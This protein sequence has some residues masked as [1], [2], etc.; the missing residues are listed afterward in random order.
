MQLLSTL[1]T[2]R[3][4]WNAQQCFKSISNVFMTEIAQEALLSLF[5]SDDKNC[6]VEID[7]ILRIFKIKLPSQFKFWLICV[8]FTKISILIMFLSIKKAKFIKIYKN[9]LFFC[10]FAQQN[11]KKV[12]KTLENHVFWYFCSKNLKILKK[13][14]KILWVSPIIHEV[15]SSKKNK[16]S[17]VTKK[18][19]KPCIWCF[20][21]FSIFFSL[22]KLT[23]NSKISLF[24]C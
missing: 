10:A 1:G 8:K 18:F 19:E 4:F 9:L 2:V 24:N 16:L 5:I 20:K 14:F 12:H 22:Q 15:S 11:M 7:T 23:N 3:V 21:S 17:I 13:I 6:Q